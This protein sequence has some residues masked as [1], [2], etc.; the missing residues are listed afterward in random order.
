MA[1]GA[2]MPEPAG[3]ADPTACGS[4]NRIAAYTFG[5]KIGE[6]ERQA[7]SNLRA[8][9]FQGTLAK[10]RDLETRLRLCALLTSR[11]TPLPL[12]TA[13]SEII[14]AEAAGGLGDTGNMAFILGR[15]KAVLNSLGATATDTRDPER[16]HALNAR[17][18][19]DMASH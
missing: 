10:S 15:A 11:G 9:L 8:R 12:E 19:H 13:Q 5:Y 7:E 14:E 16:E 3:S 17:I 1:R 18:A 4:N 2:S 6:E